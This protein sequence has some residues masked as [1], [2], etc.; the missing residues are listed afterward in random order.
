MAHLSEGYRNRLQK[1]AGILLE[2]KEKVDF[3]DAM[4]FPDTKMLP[5][6]FLLKIKKH[7][8]KAEAKGGKEDAQK[9]LDSLRTSLPEKGLYEPPRIHIYKDGKVS[10]VQGNHRIVVLKEFG[11]KKIPAQIKHVESPTH[12]DAVEITD[13]EKKMLGIYN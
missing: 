13:K 1:L 2:Q 4:K 10:M 6:D 7:D 5:V 8:R 11:Y 9:S 3:S 12:E